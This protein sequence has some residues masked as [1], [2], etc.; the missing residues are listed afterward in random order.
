MKEYL[1]LMESL[2][3]K[4]VGEISNNVLSTKVN[5]IL[6]AFKDI[7]DI[8]L[9]QESYVNLVGFAVR[10]YET[11]LVSKRD[12]DTIISYGRQMTESIENLVHIYNSC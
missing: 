4:S 1:K 3:T 9:L 11:G 5:N 7:N 12:I 2:A 6:K 10:D 8:D